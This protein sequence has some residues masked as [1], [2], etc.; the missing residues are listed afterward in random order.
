MKPKPKPRRKATEDAETIEEMI[1]IV[2]GSLESHLMFTHQKNP[3]GVEFHRQ[4][5]KEYAE[6]IVMMTKL[7]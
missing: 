5:V 7:Y 4:C 3:D 2:W 1:R 6:L